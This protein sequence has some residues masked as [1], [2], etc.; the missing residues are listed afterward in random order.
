MALLCQ[1]A[2]FQGSVRAARQT[3]ASGASIPASATRSRARTT[4]RCA[5]ARSWATG[6]SPTRR[7]A[8]S[9]RASARD[10]CAS[11]IRGG[12]ATSPTSAADA[13]ARF[14]PDIPETHR[15]RAF[16]ARYSGH[17][18]SRDAR[19]SAR[20]L[21]R[22]RRRPRIRSTSTSASPNGRAADGRG[23]RRRGRARRLGALMYES[24]ASYSACG[25]G[26]DGTDRLVA[27]AR[28]AGP[29][30]GIYG[31]KITG[32]GSGGTVALLADAGAGDAVRAIARRYA[33]ETGR[34][35]LRLR[36]QLARAPPAS[37]RFDSNPRAYDAGRGA[38][39]WYR[40]AAPPASVMMRCSVQSAR[41]SD[42][43]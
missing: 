6:S 23:V 32:G 30:R 2:E 39:R 28:E 20:T 7:A 17:D 19:R 22:S 27:L 41:S 12:T 38:R 15:R 11:T 18:R 16:L 29:A 33:E 36:R 8:R 3:C 21:R 9:R 34:D 4:A 13:F 14:A 24:H 40:A 37:A 26:S 25:L 10:T 35:A 42:A 31:A 1:P 5:S 43:A